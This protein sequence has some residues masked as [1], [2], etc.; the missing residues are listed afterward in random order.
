MADKRWAI[1]A[2]ELEK[3]MS[4]NK[5]NNSEKVAAEQVP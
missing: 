1:V 3:K 2:K 4:E 5:V